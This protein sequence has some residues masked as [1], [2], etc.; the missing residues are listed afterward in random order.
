MVGVQDYAEFNEG[1]RSLLEAAAGSVRVK[2]LIATLIPKY[3]AHFTS[4]TTEAVDVMVTLA[5]DVESTVRLHSIKVLPQVVKGESGSPIPEAVCKVTDFLVRALTNKEREGDHEH[6]LSAFEAIA[7]VDIKNVCDRL[8]TF[9]EAPEG[10]EQDILRESAC[11]LLREKICSNAKE[12]IRPFEEVEES[13]KTRIEKV[14]EVASETEFK[15]MVDILKE[16]H[17]FEVA[18]KYGPQ[19]LVDI[20][21]DQSLLQEPIDATA[22][23]ELLRVLEC[24]NI[25]LPFLQK[26]AVDNKM[27]LNIIEKIVPIYSKLEAAHQLLIL[28]RLA[29]LAPFVPKEV[30]KA[31]IPPTFDLLLAQLADAPEATE[32]NGDAAPSE[33]PGER[34]LPEV[35]F[36]CV[37]ALLFLVHQYSAKD[38]DQVTVTSGIP[39][40]ETAEPN[41]EIYKSF[42]EKLLYTYEVCETVAKKVQ[43]AIPKAKAA[44]TAE[45]QE[46]KRV[47]EQGVAS[48]K[49]ITDMCRPLVTAKPSCLQ[50]LPSGKLSW[51]ST[52]VKG[53]KRAAPLPT[54]ESKP[55]K[56]P[57]AATYVPPS[58]RGAPAEATK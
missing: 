13:L 30:A 33:N 57:V 32:D 6:C 35:A 54:A 20:I 37:E 50:S 21:A 8:L 38:P 27:S 56:K 9:M 14:L 17:I 1:F 4:Q 22:V 10:D 46:R 16:L 40:S 18:Q 53:T 44:K 45:E 24:V 19:G 55:P 28:Q 11:K 25:A 41:V 42:K 7:K 12:L 43:P 58:R 51:Q 48:I 2:S 49:N 15:T 23:D 36:T 52:V 39:F 31:C 5:D 3:A 26:G 29:D 47:L 34:A